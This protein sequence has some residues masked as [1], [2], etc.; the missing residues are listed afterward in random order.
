MRVH[1]E[2]KTYT[3]QKEKKRTQKKIHTEN[4]N[5]QKEETKERQTGLSFVK[6]SNLNHLDSRGQVEMTNLILYSEQ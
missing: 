3:Q 4:H 6:I 1:R 5:Q 2:E